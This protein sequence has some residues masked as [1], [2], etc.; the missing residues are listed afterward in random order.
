MLKDG[1]FR[2]FYTLLSMDLNEGYPDMDVYC[3]DHS[4]N[5]DARH[6]TKE[7]AKEWDYSMPDSLQAKIHEIQQSYINSGRLTNE[8]IQAL[9]A[10]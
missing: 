1:I 9:Q 7:E 6:V 8:Q 3:I 2:F 10:N 4:K 5:N